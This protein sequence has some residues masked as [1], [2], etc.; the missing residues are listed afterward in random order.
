[1][2]HA[3][4]SDTAAAGGDLYWDSSSCPDKAEYETDDN[5][6]KEQISYDVC[7]AMLA[8]NAGDLAAMEAEAA[9][10]AAARAALK[11]GLTCEVKENCEGADGEQCLKQPD[12]S[13]ACILKAGENPEGVTTSDGSQTSCIPGDT[14]QDASGNYLSPNPC[15]I[16]AARKEAEAAA[17][18]EA[19]AKKTC[20]PSENC[21]VIAGNKYG[22][23]VLDTA[24]GPNLYATEA[25]AYVLCSRYKTR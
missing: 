12:D 22:G 18:A 19:E 1:M 15:E 21:Q 16:F 10:Q 3:Y 4:H 14:F 8:K 17:A 13:Y 11:A 23:C 24:N 25:R 2:D 7:D 9:E 5:G 6:L 20:A